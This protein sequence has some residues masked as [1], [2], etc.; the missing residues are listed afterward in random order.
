MNTQLNQHAFLPDFNGA[1]SSISLTINARYQFAVTCGA[2][3][4]SAFFE[5]DDAV[6]LHAHLPASL[7]F[8]TEQARLGAAALGLDYSDYIKPCTDAFVAGYLGRIQQ[9]LRLM[10]PSNAPTFRHSNIVH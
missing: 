8:F 4:A 9:E 2:Q 1:P 10:R 5:E 7:A 6:S 3:S